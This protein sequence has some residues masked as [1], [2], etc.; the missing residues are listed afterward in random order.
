M[1]NARCCARQRLPS[2]GGGQDAEQPG[3]DN[4]VRQPKMTPAR[5]SKKDTDAPAVK[6][7]I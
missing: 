6:E 7:E 4:T 3:R 2:Q 5:P 1:F